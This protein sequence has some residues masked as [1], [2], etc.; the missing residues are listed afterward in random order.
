[1][2]CMH[3]CKAIRLVLLSPITNTGYCLDIKAFWLH[4]SSP[5]FSLPVSCC[6]YADCSIS[7]ILHNF[8][9][10]KMQCGDTVF[11][12]LLLCYFIIKHIMYFVILIYMYE[13]ICIY[14]YMFIISPTYIIYDRIR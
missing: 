4:L 2:E 12:S 3:W 6:V 10:S 5:H 13:Y 14:I 1:M 8:S 9:I 11:N 7:R